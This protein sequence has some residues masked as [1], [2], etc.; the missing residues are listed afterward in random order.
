MG[1]MIRA[2]A[3][4]FGESDALVFPDRRV[5][6]AAQNKSA[7]R[8]AAAFIALLVLFRY[9]LSRERMNAITEDLQRRKGG[10]AQPGA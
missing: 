6:Y 4:R 10:A 7:R 9:D 3:R 8:W 5:S 1:A 2:S